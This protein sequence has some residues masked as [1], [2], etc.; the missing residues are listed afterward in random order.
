MDSDN[1]SIQHKDFSPLKID[2]GN[3][4]N[5]IVTLDKGTL[6]HKGIVTHFIV[7][8][9]TKCIEAKLNHAYNNKTIVSTVYRDWIKTIDTFV[10]RAKKKGV[11]DEDILMLTDILDENSSCVIRC[12]DEKNATDVGT[13]AIEIIKEKV[14]E[15]FLDEVKTPYAAIRINDHIETMPIDDGRFEDLVGALY[16]YYK[17]EQNGGM[18]PSILPKEEISKIQSL[19]RFEASGNIN[20]RSEE[21]QNVKTLHLRIAAFLDPDVDGT[22]K[23]NSVIYYDLCNSKW[24]V[25]KISNEG[26]S[27]ETNCKEILFKRYSISSAQVHP[28]REYPLD[29]L[30][31]FMKL[32]N[33]YN[34]EDNKLLAKVYLIS[35]FVLENLPK[36]MLIPHGIHG[37]GK[38]TFQEL[39][40]LIVDPAAALTTAFPKTL[41]ELV[42]SLS[43]SYL[44]FFDNVSE[45]SDITSDQLC[46]AVT[47][48]GFVKRGLYENDK[49]IIYNMKRAVGYNGIN[50]TATRPDLLDRI[51]SIHL[52]PINKR[53]RRKLSYLQKEFQKILP[54]LLGYIF[55]ILVN[56]LNRLGEVHLDELPRMADFAELGELIA[57]CLGY[58]EGKFTQAYNRNIGFTNEEAI[59]SSPAATA[60]TIL[61]TTQPIWAGKAEDLRI[62]LNEL[63]SQK[64]ELYGLNHSKDWPKTPHA[65]SNR[66][67]EIIP[68]L[69][70]IGIVVHRE[71]DK[72]SKSSNIIITNNNY[73]PPAVATYKNNKTNDAKDEVSR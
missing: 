47:G 24:E 67:N 51:L 21:N 61:M 39:I 66:L 33:V 31:Q 4:S 52:K 14:V 10:D 17:K 35:L 37:S 71:Y 58:A 72:H 18:T 65:L 25:V 16:Y 62:R 46:R 70:E 27:I 23:A 40:K 34:D 69:N 15:L 26:W 8:G 30:E 29:I 41:A 68:N 53:D 48:S 1:T 50:I 43:H 13:Q 3:S 73:S 38:S 22:S 63:V 6:D 19:F 11:S 36:P 55:D 9:K 42:Q 54:P 5:D 12:L 45:I 49:D 7:K 2:N 60:I 28:S 20:N 56:L 32:T 44:T 64:K 59:E 57:R